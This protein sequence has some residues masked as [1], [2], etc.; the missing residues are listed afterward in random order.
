MKKRR[1][2]FK[3]ILCERPIGLTIFCL[4]GIIFC[5]T[6]CVVILK[7]EYDM[8]YR[9]VTVTGTF[10]GHRLEISEHTGF[11]P[12]LALHALS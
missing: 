10:E 12:P 1:K 9:L 2:P 11:R 6:L 3:K 8:K 4:C 7:N 5:L